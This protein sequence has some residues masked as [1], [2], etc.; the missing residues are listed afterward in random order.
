MTSISM[1][2]LPPAALLLATCVAAAQPAPHGSKP[3]PL[4]PGADAPVFRHESAFAGYRRF[5]D[6]PVTSWR[7]AND[8]VNRIGGWRV[9][10]RETAEPASAPH[11]DYAGSRPTR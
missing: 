8:T 6:E 2:G 3:D 10:G 9:Y 7:E 5:V 4:D 11:G 1:R